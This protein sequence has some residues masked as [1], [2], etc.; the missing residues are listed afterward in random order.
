MTLVHVL[1]G[2][3]LL[4]LVA[5]STVI[6]AGIGLDWGSPEPAAPDAAEETAA[7]AV[8]AVEEPVAGLV[9]PHFGPLL[10]RMRP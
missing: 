8:E 6:R 7:D 10:D 4:I 9:A 2:A 5:V 1:G 3:S